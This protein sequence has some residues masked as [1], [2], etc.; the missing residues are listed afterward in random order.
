MLF[1]LL[2]SALAADITADLDDDGVTESIRAHF[3][4]RAHLWIELEEDGRERRLD[5]ESFVDIN[6]PRRAFVIETV[7]AE[8]A[9]VPLLR[10]HVP[11]GEYCG[12]GNDWVYVSYVNGSLQKALEH[13]DF[14]DAPIW[15]TSEVEFDSKRGTARIIQEWGEE[16]RRRGR[17]VEKLRFADG[18]YE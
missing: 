14:F 12:S 7:P 11:R 16:D 5:L 10:V 9:G 17:R 4:E 2:T 13:A 18:V 15:S 3:D 1:A 8:E 6:G